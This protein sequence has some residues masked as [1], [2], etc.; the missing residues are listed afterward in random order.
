VA[1]AA[2]PVIAALVWLPAAASAASPVAVYPVPGSR[3]GSPETQITFRGI[4]ADQLGPISVTGAS[5]GSH[6]GQIE[7]AS[8]GQ[9][10]SFVPSTPFT[11][12]EVVTVKSGLNILGA[13]QGT[14]TF[15]IEQ[16]VAGIQPPGS[17]TVA[18][19]VGGDVESFRSR[20]DLVPGAVRI[21]EGRPIGDDIF[22]TPMRGPAQ[23]GPMI[24]DPA[25]RLVWFQPLPGSK[26]QAADL[27]VQQYQGHPVLTW[28]QGYQNAGLGKGED[29]I[30]DNHYRLLATVAAGN[31]LHA[32]LHEFT[33]TPQGTALLTAY[34][35][36]RWD[37]GSGKTVAV[38]D[39]VVQEIDIPTGLVLFQWDSLDHVPV[40]DSHTRPPT[41]PRP[42]DYFHVNS[43]EQLADG[44]LLVSARNTWAVYDIDHRTAGIIWTLGGKHSDFTMGKGTITAYQHHARSWPDGLFTIFDNGAAPQVHPQSRGLIE[45]VDPIKRTVTLVRALDH[46]PKLVTSYEGSVQPLPH[47]NTFVGWGAL[48]YF[49]QF[50]ANGKQIY[51]GRFVGDNSSYRAYRS[52][53]TAQPDTPPAL[54]VAGTGSGVVHVYASWNGATEVTGWRVLAGPSPHALAP[55]GAAARGGFETDVP[56]HSGEPYVAVQALDGDRTLATSAVQAVPPYVAIFGRSAFV[57]GGWIGGLPVF[58]YAD[59]ACH[60]TTTIRA[61]ATTIAHTAAVTV[62]PRSEAIVHFT[63][64]RTGHTLL[65]RARGR[66]R[67]NVSAADSAGASGSTSLTLIPFFTRGH[68]PHRSVS[69]ARSLQIVDLT[70]FVFA[71]RTGGI[72]VACQADVPCAA[73]ITVSVGATTIAH[74]GA[75][76]IGARQLGYATFSLTPAGQAMLARAPGNELAAKVT[77]T[78]GPDTATAQIALVG[79]Q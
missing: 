70:D 34:R 52:P 21:L 66:L 38:Q 54:A 19:R 25:G 58:C 11:P 18:P 56:I 27:R 36:V 60:I 16:R 49:T 40:A 43:V 33:I 15:S 68:G 2:A 65:M 53:W 42:Y 71:G 24:V 37:I 14:F 47:G 3:L 35:L 45:R 73:R 76:I 78:N 30:Y 29:V 23:W 41:R 62:G 59:H 69:Q 51:D 77:I 10:A 9:G 12:G 48:P 55:V 28:W 5:S 4:P 46:S 74:T 20:P 7:A 64:T 57:S 39:C 50:G 26:E 17:R 13:N 79:F 6:A 32:D 31:G 75:E 61:G 72:L 1:R 44:S 22:L 67:V 63:L 8:D